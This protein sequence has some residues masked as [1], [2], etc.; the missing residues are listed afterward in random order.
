MVLTSKGAAWVPGF[1]III[2]SATLA[3]AGLPLE[4]VALIAGIFRIIDSGTTTLNVLGNAI[5]PLV[6]AKWEK[7]ALEPSRVERVAQK[8]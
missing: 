7:A 3:S 1:A 4:G 8:A 5:A 2:L 6:I